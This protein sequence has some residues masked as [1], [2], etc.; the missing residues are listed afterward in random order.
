MP[1]Y[2]VA[3]PNCGPQEIVARMSEAQTFMPCGLCGR[4]RP[5][6]IHAPNFQEDR[7]R[8]WKGPLGN[9]YSHA[10]GQ[11]MPDSRSERDRIAKAK[12]VEFISLGEHLKENKEAAEALAYRQHVDS[13]G[14]RALDKPLP[15]K[16]PFVEKPQWAKDLGV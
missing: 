7:L 6:V 16:S 14:D 15:A 1:V 5:Q 12:G 11:Y 13:G 10:L 2:E 8:M 9:G 4:P 3:C